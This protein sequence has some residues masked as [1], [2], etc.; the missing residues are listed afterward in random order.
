L[1]IIGRLWA[2]CLIKPTL[3]A[4]Q[5]LWP[6]HEGDV[7]LWEYYLAKMLPYYFVVGHYARY[8][9][10]HLHEIKSLPHDARKDL[11]NGCH[12][13]RHANGAPAVS[14]EQFGGGRP[15]SRSAKDLED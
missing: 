5:F 13:C 10:V 8:I 14:A 9:P 2:D 3:I 11:L 7:L 15:I 12:V 1:R 6:E 4:L